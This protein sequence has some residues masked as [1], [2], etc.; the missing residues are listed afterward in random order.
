MTLLSRPFADALSRIGRSLTGATQPPTA[1]VPSEQDPSNK[2]FRRREE[3]SVELV[4]GS[5]AL[6][7]ISTIS[8][9][10]AT[11]SDQSAATSPT[12]SE[13]LTQLLDQKLPEA[14]KQGISARTAKLEML[15]DA[16]NLFQRAQV[17]PEARSEILTILDAS[18]LRFKSTS[19]LLLRLLS[20]VNLRS[21]DP[22]DWEVNRARK[23]ADRDKS[24]L[25]HAASEGISASGMVAYF[26][27]KGHGLEISAERGRSAS[28]EEPLTEAT[29]AKGLSA[30][31][32]IAGTAVFE[33]P[34][35]LQTDNSQE[36]SVG[37]ARVKPQKPASGGDNE[38]NL[39]SHSASTPFELI[40]N[41]SDRTTLEF[42]EA[43]ADRP[44]FL[45]VT[46][47]KNCKIIKVVGVHRPQS[48][49]I[50]RIMRLMKKQPT[51]PRKF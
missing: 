33:G 43:T 8:P 29:E 49:E 47:E 24:A 26:L 16:W 34:A 35:A 46:S 6:S 51:S 30:A 14:I 23:V 15:A 32:R 38:G 45:E 13:L 17:D 19:S 25:E 11:L 1:P 22:D 5:L 28:R 20:I 48:S 39:K 18:H 40:L 41:A 10:S 21:L 37:N 12:T 2:D 44:F 4:N 27:T 42:R 31:E 50:R 3:I 36:A 7:S 9:A